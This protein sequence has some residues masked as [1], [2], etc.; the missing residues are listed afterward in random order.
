MVR[1]VHKST[2]GTEWPETPI[3]PLTKTLAAAILVVVCTR[4]QGKPFLPE[5]DASGTWVR[6][7]ATWVNEGKMPEE[8]QL[9]VIDERVLV[10][11]C[12]F[13]DHRLA[14]C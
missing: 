7:L 14:G 1:I 13:Q 4:Y 2:N 11:L 8:S 12:G 6:G 3:H 10:L 9:S 5:E